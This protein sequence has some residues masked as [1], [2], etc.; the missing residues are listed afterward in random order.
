MKDHA[1]CYK[2]SHTFQV[3]APQGV[4]AEVSER[5]EVSRAVPPERC[6]GNAGLSA[7]TFPAEAQRAQRRRT[8][9]RGQGPPATGCGADLCGAGAVQTL[10]GGI[11]LCGYVRV[12]QGWFPL[13]LLPP[14]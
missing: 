14:P 1:F 5:Q 4:K 8:G 3:S 13:N 6:G 12:G 9:A 7:E 2:G 11:S 10:C